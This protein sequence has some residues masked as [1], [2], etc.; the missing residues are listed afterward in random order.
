MD[1]ARRSAVDRPAS[2]PWAS[3]SARSSRRSG[4][5]N[6]TSRISA[7]LMTVKTELLRPMA[8]PSA[9]TTE[10]AKRRS[11]AR[12]R[13]ANRTSCWISSSQLQP[14]S[15]RASSLASA[16]F[17]SRASSQA[18][19]ISGA[20]PIA[21]QTFPGELTMELELLGELVVRTIAPHEDEQPAQQSSRS[22]RLSM[23]V[24]IR[25]AQMST[26]VPPR[27][28]PAAATVVRFDCEAAAG[29]R[30]NVA[31]R[32]RRAARATGSRQLSSLSAWRIASAFD[33]PNAATKIAASSS[34][35]SVS[36]NLRRRRLWRV[37][38]REDAREVSS[39]ARW[40]GKSE[41]T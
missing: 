31:E 28:A 3:R 2:R 37:R 38:H 13:S 10:A 23:G 29:S 11:L 5:S 36:V 34:A 39:S 4:C 6:G 24:S 32:P 17:P 19:G 33:S 22:H 25:G 18:L 12:S 1:Q 7:V 41:H 35:G 30:R 16:T 40:P 14:H 26:A 15:S 20:Q 27:A 8:R 9:S 21:L